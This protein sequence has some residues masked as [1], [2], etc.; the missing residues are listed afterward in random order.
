MWT[1]I[2][3]PGVHTNAKLI[4][5]AYAMMYQNRTQTNKTKN[6]NSKVE[7]K[8]KTGTTTAVMMTHKKRE[9]KWD[10]NS[11]SEWG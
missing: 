8:T 10:S 11:S 7:K 5:A 9:K 4:Y 3:T 2:H 6:K 1:Y